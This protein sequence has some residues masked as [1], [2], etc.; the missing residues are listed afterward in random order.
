MIISASRRT[1]IPAFYSKWFMKRLHEGFVCVRN[2][3][4]KKQ[5]SRI[6]LHPE[7]IECIVF[8]TKDPTKFVKYLNEIKSLGFNF[9][10]Q[11]T[12]TGYGNKIEKN[13]PE[14]KKLVRI[15]KEMSDLIGKEKI[16]WRYDPILMSDDITN[17]Y[18]LN[19]FASI[20]NELKDY[21]NKCIISFL[22]MYK[23]CERNMKTVPLKEI[24]K[25]QQLKLAKSIKSIA[26]ECDLKLETCSEKIDLKHIGI[27]HGK[28]I[29]DKL[30]S[31]ITGHDLSIKKD[32]TQRNEC[33][34]VSSLDIG[35][36]NTCKHNCLY[37][38]A[39]YSYE[40]VTKKVKD[41][42]DN[43]ALLTGNLDGSEKITERKMVSFIEKQLG[44]F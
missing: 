13:V 22:D 28:C 6:N 39:N 33:G 29:D 19:A 4:N 27:P 3:F 41:H 2:P 16:I 37:C 40:T 12:L 14:K 10:F 7:H 15:F 32:P 36:Y 30:I 20:A 5:I 34:C 1:D 42:D 23:K 44:L 43:S 26:R 8:W 35:A 18:H 11:F 21:T 31:K 38:Y 17:G 25:E 9:Y 24:T